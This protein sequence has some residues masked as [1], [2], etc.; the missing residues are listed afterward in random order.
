MTQEIKDKIAEL[1]AALEAGDP[2]MASNIMVIY[3]QLKETPEA[4]HL[5]TEEEI[6]TIVKGFEVSSGNKIVAPAK[7]ATTKSSIAKIDIDDL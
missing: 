7:K 4:V 3:K 6:A 1:G 5:L 2:S